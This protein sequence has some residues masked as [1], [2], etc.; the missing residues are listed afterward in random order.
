[1]KRRLISLASILLFSFNVCAG[2]EQPVTEANRIDQP[3]L[4][5]SMARMINITSRLHYYKFNADKAFAQQALTSV[6][7]NIDKNNFYF[8]RDDLASFA[9]Y[10]NQMIPLMVSRELRVA[11]HLF[12][13]AIGIVVRR[14][15]LAM[16]QIPVAVRTPV[17]TKGSVFLTNRAQSEEALAQF[18]LK[19]LKHEAALLRLAGVTDK[20]LPQVLTQRYKALIDVW[21]SLNGEQ[22]FNML[23]DGILAAH[24]PRTTYLTGTELKSSRK[25]FSGVYQG[26]GI[27]AA[28]IEGNASVGYIA[29]EARHLDIQ[30]ADVILAVQ[31]GK[32][33]LYPYAGNIESVSELLRLE[34]A[35]E[36]K[37]KLLRFDAGAEAVIEM[38]LPR[39]QRKKNEIRTRF[40]GA[41]GKTAQLSFD[42]FY[43]G[44]SK[45]L[46]ERLLILKKAGIN[47]VVIDLRGNGGGSLMEALLVSGLFIDKGAVM[48][49]LFAGG[50]KDIKEDTDGAAYFSGSLVL[51]VDGVSAGATEIFAAA[52]QDY[53]VGLVVGERTYG[54]GVVAQHRDLARIYDLFEQP[55]GSMRFTIGEYFRLDG[56]GYHGIGVTPDVVVNWQF[57]YEYTTAF[58]GRDPVALD[59]KAT[60]FKPRHDLAPLIKQLRKID[61]KLSD[62]ERVALYAEKLEGF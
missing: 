22:K 50:K 26:A 17:I 51:M 33:W 28:L 62:D 18:W 8:T 43:N 48:Q 2:N 4:S 54:M 46:T 10:Q 11:D 35:K 24:D 16:M 44:L 61:S 19:R 58:V 20:Q 31:S 32:D 34:H 6:L 38:S 27:S 59:I 45:E 13:D 9:A 40:I 42:S 41:D 21:R 15:E 55:L 37:V 47:R 57:A 36:I 25:V 49:L 30:V 39:I 3:H 29:F 12:N 53:G 60:A 56:S 5:A 1:M 52:V 23:A 7:D 14:L